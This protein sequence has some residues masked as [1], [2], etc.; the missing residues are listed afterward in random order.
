M[1]SYTISFNSWLVLDS[2][3]YL[4]LGILIFSR[5]LLKG[6]GVTSTIRN[7]HGPCPIPSSEGYK[8]RVP[9][10]YI[11]VEL[12]NSSVPQRNP[13]GGR[14]R[15]WSKFWF[16]Y[17]AYIVFYCSSQ[18]PRVRKTFLNLYT[19]ALEVGFVFEFTERDSDANQRKRTGSWCLTCNVRSV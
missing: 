14:H 1:K 10:V 3:R 19:T 9:C 4:M 17:I 2:W 15:T 7:C 18:N 5:A 8:E 6:W 13:L 12:Y 16:L 11:F